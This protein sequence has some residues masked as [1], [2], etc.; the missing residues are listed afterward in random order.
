[1]LRWPHGRAMYLWDPE[2]NY[3]ELES[4]EDLPAAFGKR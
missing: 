1:V 3:I 2:G 4:E